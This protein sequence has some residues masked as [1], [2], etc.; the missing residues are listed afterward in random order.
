MSTPSYK[1]LLYGISHKI[2]EKKNPPAGDMLNT[3]ELL[4]EGEPQQQPLTTAAPERDTEA[5]DT[6]GPAAATDS[7]PQ[8]LLPHPEDVPICSTRSPPTLSQLHSKVDLLSLEVSRIKKQ[9]SPT[10]MV[11]SSSRHLS[12]SSR[13]PSS[14]RSWTR[15]SVGGDLACRLLV[16]LFPELFSDVTSPAGLWRLRLCG[17]AEAGVAAPA[18]Y[19]ELREVYYPSVKDLGSLAG[20][21]P[22]SAQRFLQPLWAQREMEDSQPSGQV[23]GFFE[24][25]PRGWMLATSWTAR[26]RRRPCLGPQQHHRL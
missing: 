24:A 15:A 9:V 17:Q 20:R 3:Y 5:R 8:H 25:E 14:S 11:A 16:Q 4:R 2:M 6:G 23:S 10:E 19:P 22:A 26:S 18:A 7:D 13:R 12:T 21:V 1:K